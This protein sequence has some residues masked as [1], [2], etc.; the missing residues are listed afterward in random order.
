M[1]VYLP[2]I[3]KEGDIIVIEDHMTKK[4]QEV[5]LPGLFFP[6]KEPNAS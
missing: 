4:Q 1:S 6:I 5:F 3:I 2:S